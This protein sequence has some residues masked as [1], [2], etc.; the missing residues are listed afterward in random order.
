MKNSSLGTKLLMTAVTLAVLVYFGIQGLRYFAD[1]FSTTVAYT[2]QVEKNISATG[3]V[4]RDEEVLAD[5]AGG[6]LRLSRAEGERVSDGGLVGVIYADQASLDRQEEISSLQ[7]R[8]EQLRYAQEAA[9]GAEVSLKL[10]S[11]IAGSI[12]ELRTDLTADR[13]AAA[14]DHVANLR[15]LV[16]KRD[17]TYTDTADVSAQIAELEA[18][19]KSLRSQT[20]SSTKRLTAPQAG[21][22][23]AVVDGY[24]TVLTPDSLKD[25]T[26]SALSALKPDDAVSSRVGKLIL[27]DE[28][29]YVAS[30]RNEDAKELKE[31]GRVSLRFAK[32]VEREL[33]VTVTAVGPE[34]NGRAV[35]TF[36]GRTYLPQLTLLRQQSAELVRETISGIRVPQEALRAQKVSVDEAGSRT[37]TEEVGVYCVV[38]MEAKF[39]PVE[40]LY[41]GDGFTLVRSALG[42]SSEVLP[43]QEKTRLRPGDEV[44]LAASDL[45][46]GKV[47]G[48]AVK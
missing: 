43:S 8:I 45:Y 25:L 38:G 46:D 15:A 9:M 23:S 34:E 20:A 39:K 37:V 42:G 24:E 40:V 1:P 47:V 22:Y 2:Y 21:I 14:E 12:L 11:Q 13:L 32:D 29:Y 36:R 4:V 41:Q 16:L 10:D 7:T 6:L 30:L 33:S 3:F 44:I 27:G 18:Q 48:Q 19:V 28:W 26:P 31:E 5:S 35:V 17:Y